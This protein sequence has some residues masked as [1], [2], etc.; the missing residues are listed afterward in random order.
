MSQVPK[1]IELEDGLVREA[2]YL[3]ARGVRPMA[4]VYDGAADRLSMLQTAT[5]LER[6]GDPGCIPLVV[7]HNDGRA[8]CGFASAQWVIDLYQWITSGVAVPPEHRH[9]ILGL[10]LGY[11]TSAIDEHLQALSGRR[12]QSPTRVETSS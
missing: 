7:D 3:V 11:S 1:S 8:G 10:L 2:A 9:A 4:L 5:Q 6:L 12:F